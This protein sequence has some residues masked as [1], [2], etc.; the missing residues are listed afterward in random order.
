MMEEMW[1]KVISMSDLPVAFI[2]INRPP[3]E[4]RTWDAQ[5]ANVCYEIE[6]EN[7]NFTPS[8][9]CTEIWFFNLQ[10]LEWMTLFENVK[11]VFEKLF[12]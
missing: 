3:H 12:S 4:N 2:I 9:E 8:D 11:P 7:L 5:I 10:D 6:V 1:L